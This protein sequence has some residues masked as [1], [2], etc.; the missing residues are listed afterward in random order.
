MCNMIV[1]FSSLSIFEKL[2]RIDQSN[3]ML[4]LYLWYSDEAG[5]HMCSFKSRWIITWPNLIRALVE[6]K[7]VYVNPTWNFLTGSLRPRLVRGMSIPL[8]KWITIPWNRWRWN[9]IT[10]PIL[11]FGCNGGIEHCICILLFGTVQYIGEL[12]HIIIKFPKV[13]L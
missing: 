9:E 13:P 11:L 7:M 8:G 3:Q 1:V 5:N 4:L 2:K 12:N 6:L 10:I